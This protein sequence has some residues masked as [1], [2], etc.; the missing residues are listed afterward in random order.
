LNF[1]EA[2]KKLKTM[3]LNKLESS[4]VPLKLIYRQEL[5]KELQ[6]E[7]KN[8]EKDRFV[9]FKLHSRINNIMPLFFFRAPANWV[10]KF[11]PF[12]KSSK[13]TSES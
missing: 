13:D 1:A 3:E 2:C 6:E 5:I 4:I 8:L 12:H 11:N 9:H 7:K 10:S